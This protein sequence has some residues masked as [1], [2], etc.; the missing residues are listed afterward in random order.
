MLCT[1]TYFLF[2]LAKGLG[3]GLGAALLQAARV[4]YGLRE[5]YA[6]PS[7]DNASRGRCMREYSIVYAF[8][9]LCLY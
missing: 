8:L 5:A 1:F 4:A 2:S 6:T 9:I 3:L 7:R